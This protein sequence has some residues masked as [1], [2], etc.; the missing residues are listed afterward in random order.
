MFIIFIFAFLQALSARSLPAGCI[1]TT[2]EDRLI[3]NFP[4]LQTLNYNIRGTDY[5]MTSS[6]Q[7][8]IV[9]KVF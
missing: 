4:F 2:G 8:Y 6:Q 9:K 7:T 5:E 1:E 3:L